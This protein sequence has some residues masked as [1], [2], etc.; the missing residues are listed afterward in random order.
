[1][2][3]QDKEQ[4]LTILKFKIFRF[5]MA[6]NFPGYVIN[7]TTIAV[8]HWPRANNSHITHYFLTHAHTDHT[9][10]L[11]ETWNGPALYCSNVTNQP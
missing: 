6:N 7:N 9:K 5:K 10:G 4:K 11:D 1:M 3:A 8:D 2:A